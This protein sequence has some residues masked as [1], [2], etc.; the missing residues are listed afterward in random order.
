[1]VCLQFREECGDAVV[2]ERNETRQYSKRLKHST[3]VR[4]V[5]RVVALRQP[6]EGK[7]TQSH[8]WNSLQFCKQVRLRHDYHGLQAAQLSPLKSRNP[9]RYGNP[10]T[11]PTSTSS[12][13]AQSLHSP[14]PTTR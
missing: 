2:H 1:M 11:D 10:T 9:L 8:G 5:F 3:H 12:S 4:H 13:L 6:D 14:P 7:I